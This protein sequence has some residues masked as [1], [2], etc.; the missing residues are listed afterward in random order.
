MEIETGPGMYSTPDEDSYSVDFAI[1]AINH[2]YPGCTRTYLGMAGHM[3]A[4]YGK[5]TNP[6]AGLLHDQ[7]VIAS[8]AIIN[9]PT[10]MGYFTRWRV[11]CVSISEASEILAGCKRLEKENWRQARWE[12]QNRFS[13]VQLDSTLSATTR[14]FQSQAAPP[15]SREDDGPRA[16]PIQSGLAGGSPTPGLSAGSPVRRT[17]LGHRHSSDDDGVSTD[18]S[19]S[20]KALHRR[21][22]SQG[23]KVTGVVVTLMKLTPLEGGKRKRMDFLARSK[24]LNLGTRRVILMM[25]I[26]PLGSGPIVSLITVTIMRIPTSC[27]WWCPP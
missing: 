27:P 23:V 11:Q 3:L 13:S 26:M 22:G 6:R 15:P 18:T 21:C 5:K 24:S 10:W 25:W 12:L 1:D 8:K 19:I 4:F 7:A 16:Y 20:D 9:I 14:P 17:S 2:T